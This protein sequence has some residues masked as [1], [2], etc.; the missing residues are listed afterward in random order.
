MKKIIF[1]SLLA[2]LCIVGLL[3]L[4]DYVVLLSNRAQLDAVR[5]RHRSSLLCG[6]AKDG[7][8]GIRF[9]VFATG[10]FRDFAIPAYRLLTLLVCAQAH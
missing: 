3:Y 1:K 6:A 7:K 10:D 5:H 2:L 4:G 9:P 8:D